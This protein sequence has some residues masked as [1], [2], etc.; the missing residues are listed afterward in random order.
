VNAAWQGSDVVLLRRD[1][2]GRLRK[3]RVAAEH[4]CYLRAADVDAELERGLRDSRHVAG[5]KKEGEWVRVRWRSRDACRAACGSEGWFDERHIEVFEGDVNPVRR[6][7]TDNDVSIQ[8]PRRCYVDLETDSRVP[9]RRA[10]EGEARVLCWSLV[11]DDGFE[12]VRLLERDDDAAEAALLEELWRVLFDYDQVISWNGDRWDFPIVWVR[13]SMHR[14][15]VDPR[16][17]LWLDHLE[18]FRTMNMHSAESG[19]EKQS[20]ALGRVAESLGLDGKLDVDA[21]RS[22]EYWEAGGDDRRELA[23]YCLHDSR[24]MTQIEERTGFVD[25]LYTLADVCGVFPDSRGMNATNYVESFLLRL[26]RKRGIRFRSHWGAQHT[27]PFAGAYV[28]EP[29]RKGILKNVHVADFSGMY[30]S[31][32]QTW[33]ISP[34]TLRPD[35][36]LREDVALRPTYLMHAP[37]KEYPRPPGVCEVPILGHAFATDGRGVLPEAIDALIEMSRE[38]NERKAKLPPGTDEWKEADRRTGAYKIARNSFYG[39]TGSP[40]SR[41]GQ[42]EIA[43]SITQAGVWLL[44]ETIRAG[45]ERGIHALAGDTDSEFAMDCTEDEFADFVEWCNRELYP[46]LVAGLGCERN[47]IK[48]AYEKAF[49]RIV[50]VGKK[51][52]CGRYSHFKGARADEHSRPEVKGLEYKRGDTVRMARRMQAQSIELLLGGGITRLRG[53]YCEE[54]P[55]VFAELVRLW[56]WRVLEGS[57]ERRDYVLAKR[58]SKDPKHYHRKT[59]KDGGKTALPPHVEVALKLRE[60]GHDMSEGSLVEYVVVD[61]GS[62]PQKVVAA[63]EHEPGGEDRFYL[64]E[65]MVYPPTQR[66]LEAAF[67]GHPWKSYL[68]ARPPKPRKLPA[69]AADGSPKARRGRSLPGQRSLF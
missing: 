53:E 18:L 58:L 52:Y 31:I 13:S 46:A 17:W 25:L 4:T 23:E 10:A 39:A 64:W 28:M 7:M 66:L 35:V 11:G 2:S 62:A 45:E 38:W 9:P 44:K 42:R 57:L 26:G 51:R 40:F 63:V 47:E 50:M 32:I 1:A 15:K 61:G 19:D 67:P 49:E 56:K 14:V 16:R 20:M 65:S 30:P 68:R 27:E 8:R 24:L 48:L 12:D 34:E 60:L 59:K 36:V 69:R 54:D 29:T 5:V 43:E 6:Y 21:S 55:A 3:E 37:V 33:N 22:W 41:F